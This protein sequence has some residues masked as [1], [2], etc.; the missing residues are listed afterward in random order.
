M[1]RMLCRVITA[2]VQWTLL[3]ADYTGMEGAKWGKGK[4]SITTHSM[5]IVKYSDSVT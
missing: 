1:Q 2:A 4:K 3:T 5:Q